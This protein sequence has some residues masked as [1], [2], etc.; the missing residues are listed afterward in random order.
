MIETLPAN[1]QKKPV[2]EFQDS[3]RYLQPLLQAIFDEDDIL[4]K[5]TSEACFND[6]AN[7]NQGYPDDCIENDNYTLG[8][9]EV[10]PVGKAKNP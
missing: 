5:W 8:Y 4:L 6:V 9:F 10:K 3:T 1:S 7:D 2:L